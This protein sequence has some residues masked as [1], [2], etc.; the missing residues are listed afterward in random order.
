MLSSTT[1]LLL[2]GNTPRTLI[3][4]S[5]SMK[6]RPMQLHAM[7][8]STGGGKAPYQLVLV[9]HGESTWN[10]ENKFTG[11][12]DCPLSVKGHKEAQDAGILLK[13]AGLTFD[14]AYTSTLQR[15]IRT[16]WHSLEE[17]GFMYIPIVCAWQ[18]N[19]R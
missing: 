9:R 11:W 16:L 2:R 12:Y 3:S 14:L 6:S 15:A 13:K 4:Q 8:M 5:V 10:Q 7:K 17:T 1:S 19:E 18:L